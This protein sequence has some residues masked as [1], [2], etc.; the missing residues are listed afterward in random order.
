MFDFSFS[1]IFPG[2]IYSTPFLVECE[3]PNIR[4]DQLT[5]RHSLME[6]IGLWFVW[7]AYLFEKFKFL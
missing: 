1:F 3:H 7:N 2:G 4:W 5:D 6:L